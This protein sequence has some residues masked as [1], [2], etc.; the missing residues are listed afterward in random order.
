[1]QKYVRKH[2]KVELKNCHQICY[3]LG[4]F[5]KTEVEDLL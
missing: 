4:Q 3:Y 5:W 2:C 1:M